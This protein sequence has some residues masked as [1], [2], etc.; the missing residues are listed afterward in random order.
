MCPLH[1]DV[2]VPQTALYGLDVVSKPQ[3]H[4]I[5]VAMAAVLVSAGHQT[6][7][8]HFHRLRR[9]V[10]TQAYVLGIVFFLW[11]IWRS[12]VHSL[13][14]GDFGPGEA[15]STTVF[16]SLFCLISVSVVYIDACADFAS[17][18]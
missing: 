15:R 5:S 2:E 6:N 7:A 11:R 9:L 18:L 8:Y 17:P 13:P 4:I 12:D 16:R 3:T 1:V 10:S 14:A